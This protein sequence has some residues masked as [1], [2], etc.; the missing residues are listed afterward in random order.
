MG[1]NTKN[2]II[3]KETQKIVAKKLTSDQIFVLL[4]LIISAVLLYFIISK[5]MSDINSRLDKLIDLNTQNLD[6][7][8]NHLT[9]YDAKDN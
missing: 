5:N 2:D 3:S 1:S 4:V 9:S 8:R 6:V 7:L